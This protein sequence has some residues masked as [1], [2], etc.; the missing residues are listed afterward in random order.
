MASQEMVYLDFDRFEREEFD[1]EFS[2]KKIDEEQY[3]KEKDDLKITPLTEREIRELEF[4]A[5]K[6]KVSKQE[7]ASKKLRLPCKMNET[8]DFCDNVCQFKQFCSHRKL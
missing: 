5:S 7:Y 4:N 2:H 3:L 1:K 6:G 8:L